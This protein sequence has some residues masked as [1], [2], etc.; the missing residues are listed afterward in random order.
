MFLEIKESGLL[1]YYISKELEYDLN[2]GNIIFVAFYCGSSCLNTS[3]FRLGEESGSI[4]SEDAC[5]TVNPYRPLAISG[6]FDEPS[7][8]S[9]ET[10]TR[11]NRLFWDRQI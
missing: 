11:N 6:L 8:G 1:Y 10:G 7:P 5:R 9:L 3:S 2:L 4:G